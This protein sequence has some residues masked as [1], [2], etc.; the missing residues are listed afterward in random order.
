MSKRKYYAYLTN[1]TGASLD[2]PTYTYNLY[3]LKQYIRAN[4]S[5]FQVH[6]LAV[7]LDG[8]GQSVTTEPHEVETFKLR[9]P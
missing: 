2:V 5:G 3:E 1:D 6:I 9:G 8:D 4:Y 7:D